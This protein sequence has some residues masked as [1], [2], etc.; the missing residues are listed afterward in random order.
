MRAL[1]R[2]GALLLLAGQA[3]AAGPALS[4]NGVPIDGVVNQR[5]ENVT[6]VIDE[7]G[8]VNILARG[9]SVSRPEPEPA[10]APA[11]PPSPPAAAG[12]PR[13]FGTLT[14]RYFLVAQQTEPG[15]TEYDVSVFLNGRWVR[16]VRS[17]SD[18]EP[19]E[20]TRFLQPGA[21]KVVLVATKRLAGAVRRS[22][23]REQ[24]LQI[25]VG[26]GSGGP[27]PLESPQVLMTRTAAETETVTEEH[28]LVAR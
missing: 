28:N 25:L 18:A 21:N 7:R 16:E 1:A 23:S 3:R 27:A 19:F 8:N 9:Y 26:E 13:P 24:K 12:E 10:T 17:D 15:M 5:F 2:A 11:T 6:V 22:S 14:H 20:I 4:L